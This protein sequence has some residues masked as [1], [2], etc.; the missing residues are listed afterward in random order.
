MLITGD[1]D[2]YLPPP[3]LRTV[4]AHMPRSRVEIIKEAGHSV[5]WEQ[6]RVFNRMLLDFLS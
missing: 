1:A 6:P 4:A 5:H 3:V 2:L